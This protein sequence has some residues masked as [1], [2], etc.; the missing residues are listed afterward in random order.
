MILL[1]L[2][3]LNMKNEPVNYRAPQPPQIYEIHSFYVVSVWCDN[4]QM[5]G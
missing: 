2:L 4:V 3:L 1:L 5:I